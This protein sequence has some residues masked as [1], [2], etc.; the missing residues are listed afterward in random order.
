MTPEQERLIEED[1]DGPPSESGFGRGSWN[2]GVVARRIGGRFGIACSRRIAL[3]IAGRLGFSTCKPWSIPY[4]GAAPEEQAA[5]I[6]RTKWTI[7]GWK[8][9]GRTVPAVDAATLRDS[10]T[11]GR[12]LRR[13]AERTSSAPTTTPAKSGNITMV[14]VDGWPWYRSLM[15]RSSFRYSR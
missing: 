7:A 4:N 3:R 1:P 13:R 11:S 14:I 8:E 15:S 9:E 2:S 10:P 6:E 12:G 5:F